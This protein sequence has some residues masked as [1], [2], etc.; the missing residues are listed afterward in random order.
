MTEYSR[1]TP[2]LLLVDIWLIGLETTNENKF[3]CRMLCLFTIL[4]AWFIQMFRRHHCSV[5]NNYIVY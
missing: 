3:C 2:W 1:S 5:F 4:L